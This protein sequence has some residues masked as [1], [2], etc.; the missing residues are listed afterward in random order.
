M[1]FEAFKDKD[2][3]AKLFHKHE[4]VGDDELAKFKKTC[5]KEKLIFTASVTGLTRTSVRVSAVPSLPKPACACSAASCHLPCPL[6]D[7]GW[8]LHG[9]FS[10]LHAY[11]YLCR[12]TAVQTA[13]CKRSP[14]AVAGPSSNENHYSVNVAC[15]SSPL[16]YAL[17][18]QCPESACG[19]SSQ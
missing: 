12:S 17:P 11:I 6:G 2:I 13:A 8:F 3:F 14:S 16:T 7:P 10:F 1:Y 18:P 9:M 15:V 5:K 19:I 4:D